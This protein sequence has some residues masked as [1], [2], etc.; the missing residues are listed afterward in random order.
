MYIQY[1]STNV[2]INMLTGANAMQRM[3]KHGN[4]TESFVCYKLWASRGCCIH[5]SSSD[6]IK[7]VRAGCQLHGTHTDT[8]TIA[9]SKYVLELLFITHWKVKQR[10]NV[11]INSFSKETGSNKLL[12]RCLSVNETS[13]AAVA[14]LPNGVVPSSISLPSGREWGQVLHSVL[15][16]RWPHRVGQ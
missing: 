3:G 5:S 12:V 8:L 14:V 4:W 10:K 1:N 13:N 7:T 6:Y 9:H 2:T 16:W 15:L 11:L